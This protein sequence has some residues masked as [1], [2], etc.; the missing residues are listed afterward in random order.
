MKFAGK[1]DLLLIAAVAAAA[2]LL[3]AFMNN[4]VGKA[5]AYAEIY[6]KSR[7]VRTVALDEGA[8]ESFSIPELPE[9]VLRLYGD[10]SIA[11]VESDCPDK[12]CIHAGRL[13]LAGQTAACLPNEIYMKII[14]AKGDADAPDL[15]VG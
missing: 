3:F 15:I 1:R 7:L 10:G 11:F 6:Y 13:R 14:S 8:E 9:V 2:L 12:V 4:A 5:G